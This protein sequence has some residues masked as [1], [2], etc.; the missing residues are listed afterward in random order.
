MIG[1][2]YAVPLMGGLL[3]GPA[4]AVPAGCG[5]VIYYLMKYLSQN[6]TSL[7]TG[8]V[9]SGATKSDWRLVSEVGDETCRILAGGTNVST[10]P[11]ETIAEIVR[12]TGA[13]A[14]EIG[15]VDKIGT[16]EDA[17]NYAVLSVDGAE[18]LQDVQIVEYPKPQ[19]TLEILLEELT[20][21]ETV[22][23]GT[24]LEN[25]GAAFRR[26]TSAQTGKAYARI[27]YEIVLN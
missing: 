3:F 10:M 2:P 7:G 21:E 14:L 26:V 17:L 24:P 11:M 22:F 4:A 13:E 8:E 6:T 19:T 12:R 5:A 20:G 15:L 1:I 18:S 27:P 23:A 9:E 25:I 16:L